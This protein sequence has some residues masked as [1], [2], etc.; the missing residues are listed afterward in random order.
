MTDNHKELSR[1]E[2]SMT[3]GA[4]ADGDTIRDRTQESSAGLTVG[5]PP[6]CGEPGYHRVHGEETK[7]APEASL[8]ANRPRCETARGL[9][10]DAD[11]LSKPVCEH[12]ETDAAA[13][14]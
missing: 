7:L 9:V 10:P 5:T 8:K 6:V 12:R 13:E 14:P 11:R 4:R 1:H 2:M 3:E